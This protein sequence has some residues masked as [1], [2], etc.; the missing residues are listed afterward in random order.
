[1]V[2]SKGK[3][4]ENWERARMRAWDPRPEGQE[5]GLTSVRKWDDSVKADVAGSD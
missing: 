1:M 3:W 2:W 5:A 4:C